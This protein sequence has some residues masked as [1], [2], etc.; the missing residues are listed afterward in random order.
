MKPQNIIIHWHDR[1]RSNVK[2]KFM[3]CGWTYLYSVSLR[4][5]VIGNDNLIHPCQ[6][7]SFTLCIRT[8]QYALLFK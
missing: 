7:H 6:A 2:R 4:K 5:Y 1:N 3:F 8:V